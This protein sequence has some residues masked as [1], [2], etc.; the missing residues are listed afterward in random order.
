[1]ATTV[2]G[3]NMTASALANL[4]RDKGRKHLT[5]IPTTQVTVT[6]SNGTPFTLDVGNVWAP[7]PAPLNDIVF[8]GTGTMITG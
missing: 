4:P 7:Y 2:A 5:V 3:I 6:I 8:T 1:M